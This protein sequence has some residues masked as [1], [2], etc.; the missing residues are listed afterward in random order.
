M[1]IGIIG[2]ENM[3]R[4]PGTLW[5]EQGH[6]TLLINRIADPAYFSKFTSALTTNS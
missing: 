2:S 4:S 3:G 5:S 1:K 6:E